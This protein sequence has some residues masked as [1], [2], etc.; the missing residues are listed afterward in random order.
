MRVEKLIG[1]PS[2]NLAC[3]LA[4][5]DKE[6]DC[7]A[8]LQKCKEAGTLPDAVHLN[9]DPDLVGYYDR[10]WFKDLVASAGAGV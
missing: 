10:P 3:V 2:Y 7:M 1:E 9:S 5:Q 4:L 6:A 8:Q